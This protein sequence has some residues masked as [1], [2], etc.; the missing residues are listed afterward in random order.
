MKHI[1]DILKGK[2]DTIFNS[3]GSICRTANLIRQLSIHQL[4]H[5]LGDKVFSTG[6][7]VFGTVTVRSKNPSYA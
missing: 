7:P 6:L 3:V 1:V 5:S 2:V 4:Q